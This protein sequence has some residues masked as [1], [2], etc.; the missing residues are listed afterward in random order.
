MIVRLATIEEL[1]EW[2]DKRIAK[3]PNDNSWVVWKKSFI[4]E[5]LN[6]KRKT[7]FAFDNSGKFIGQCTLLL[8]SEDKV[9]TG[10]HKAEIIKLELVAE[11]RGK[12]LATK[13]YNAVKDYAKQQGVKTLTIGVEPCEIKNMQIYFHWGFTNFLQCIT[14]IY[15]PANKDV[16]G[17]VVTVLCYSQEI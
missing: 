3:S 17:K 5:N 1:N 12:G 11:E 13:I 15:P 16:E 8:E 6:G 14:E 4:E 2:W 10:N 9:M 7:F